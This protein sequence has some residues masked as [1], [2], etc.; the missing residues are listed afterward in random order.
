MELTRFEKYY[1]GI[2]NNSYV[3]RLFHTLL[4]KVEREPHR[5]WTH[6]SLRN[7][8]NATYELCSSLN[9]R[10]SEK[11]C[12]SVNQRNPE[13]SDK[14]IINFG[15]DDNELQF[16]FTGLY[17]SGTY[18]GLKNGLYFVGNPSKGF[19]VKTRKD[20]FETKEFDGKKVLNNINHRDSF[21]NELV[22][23]DAL[24]IQ[25]IILPK[26]MESKNALDAL[27]ANKDK[28][29][30]EG[31][32]WLHI[33]RDGIDNLPTDFVKSFFNKSY[34]VSNPQDIYKNRKKW[35]EDCIQKSADEDSKDKSFKYYQEIMLETMQSMVDESII[36]NLPVM[37]YIKNA[38][39]NYLLPMCLMNSGKPDFC[40]VLKHI[41]LK[42]KEEDDKYTGE[43][44]PVTSLNM[45]EAYC[46]I[47]VFGKD[48]IERVR[49]W[50]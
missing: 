28:E 6:N 33:L 46:D 49:D 20:I 50:W 40:I 43:W 23:K 15:S 16:F 41:V 45:D 14:P 7:Y 3:I 2:K 42:H 13:K 5:Q 48:A 47:R 9:Q 8:V 4:Q 29:R 38:T 26:P 36:H 22:D 32:S 31:N 17:T 34:E 21:E 19:S 25:N 11:S 18:H 39:Y 1:L 30:I 24:N 27:N 10:D 37:F 12:Q 44:E 35:I